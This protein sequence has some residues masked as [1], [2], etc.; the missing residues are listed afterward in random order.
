MNNDINDII[1]FPHCFENDIGFTC[2][3]FHCY[4]NTPSNHLAV[5]LTQQAQRRFIVLSMGSKFKLRPFVA[6]HSLLYWCVP[7]RQQYTYEILKAKHIIL[8][9]GGSF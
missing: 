5:Y 9:V 4:L 8:H 3:G 1:G 7:F 2:V 6:H